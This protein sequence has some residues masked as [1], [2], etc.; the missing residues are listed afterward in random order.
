[1]SSCVTVFVIGDKPCD[2][3]EAAAGLLYTDPLLLHLLR[4]QRHRQLQFVLHLYLRD[5]RVGS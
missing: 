2:Q 1:M 5:V 4:Q 3:Q